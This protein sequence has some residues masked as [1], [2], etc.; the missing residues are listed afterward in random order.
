V[1]PWERPLLSI[2]PRIVGGTTTAEQMASLANVY[3]SPAPGL[4]TRFCRV[5][6]F[7]YQFTVRRERSHCSCWWS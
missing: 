7:A 4:V 5:S 6:R 2:T 3:A 1:L